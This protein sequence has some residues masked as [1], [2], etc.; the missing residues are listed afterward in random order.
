MAC[1]CS[2]VQVRY[3]GSVPLVDALPEPPPVG[4]LAAGCFLGGAGGTS[5]ERIGAAGFRTAYDEH[6]ASTSVI[7]A[8][9]AGSMVSFQRLLTATKFLTYAHR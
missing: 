6:L 7:E 3:R 1:L 4:T 9:S 5:L 2:S 8:F